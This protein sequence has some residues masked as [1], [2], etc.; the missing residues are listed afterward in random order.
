MEPLGIEGLPIVGRVR[1]TLAGKQA[2]AR[3]TIENQE[4]KKRE[5]IYAVSGA[6][7]KEQD[8]GQFLQN[9]MVFSEAYSPLRVVELVYRKNGKDKVCWAL[10]AERKRDCEEEKLPKERTDH[11]ERDAKG[12]VKI[13]LYA[14]EQSITE[15]MVTP[16]GG[17]FKLPEGWRD[18]TESKRIS[19][20]G[21]L[22]WAR[23][24]GDP[25]AQLAN[26]FRKR[27][28]SRTPQLADFEGVIDTGDHYLFGEKGNHAE[29][30]SAKFINVDDLRGSDLQKAHDSIQRDYKTED[31]AVKRK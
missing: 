27:L 20:V 8:F 23:R 7:L 13:F 28:V 2:E 17:C 5:R 24:S 9:G 25:E 26:E 22:A 16:E 21:V 10:T 1:A 12:R 11:S 6:F 15:V 18:N 4:R 19:A 31:K 14:G 30:V 3:D 29:V